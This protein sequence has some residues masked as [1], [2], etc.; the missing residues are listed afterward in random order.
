MVQIGTSEFKDFNDIARY[1]TK[2]IQTMGKVF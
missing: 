1:M 2:L